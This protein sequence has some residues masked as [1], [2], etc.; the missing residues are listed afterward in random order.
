[1]SVDNDE[2]QD[3]AD[4]SIRTICIRE[5]VDYWVVGVGQGLKWTCEVLITRD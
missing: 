1:M 4:V 2:K 3:N 5:I